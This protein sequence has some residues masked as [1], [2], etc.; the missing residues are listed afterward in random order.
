MKKFADTLIRESVASAMQQNKLPEE[1][2]VVD[3]H[4]ALLRLPKCDFL[5]NS[6]LGYVKEETGEA[7]STGNTNSDKGA[8]NHVEQ[9]IV[10]TELWATCVKTETEDS[11]MEAESSNHGLSSTMGSVGSNLNLGLSSTMGSVGSNLN[12]KVEAMDES[13]NESRSFMMRSHF[14]PGDRAYSDRALSISR[15]SSLASMTDFEPHFEIPPF[16]QDD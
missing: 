4:R 16:V 7:N 3:V 14:S 11:F 1:L 8:M 5:R 9:P 2:S 15:T 6:Y 13:S 12:L 10:K